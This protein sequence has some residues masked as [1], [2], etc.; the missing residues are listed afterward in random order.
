[1]DNMSELF[2]SFGETIHV[3]DIELPNGGIYKGDAIKK[4]GS[5]IEIS[6][7]GEVVFPN[8]DQYVGEWKYGSH[9]GMEL[10]YLKMGISIKDG[11]MITNQKVQDI[12]V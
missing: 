12:C 10:I 1:M 6:G 5:M 11:L 2:D 8:G 3:E 9:M 7:K 4:I